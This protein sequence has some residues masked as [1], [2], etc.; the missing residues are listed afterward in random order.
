MA[1]INWPDWVRDGVT[2]ARDRSGS[3]YLYDSSIVELREDCFWPS[4]ITKAVSFDELESLT[5]LPADFI[6]EEYLALDWKQSKVT[7]EEA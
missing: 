1:L 2:I 3:M 6:T 5:D 4:D 7:K